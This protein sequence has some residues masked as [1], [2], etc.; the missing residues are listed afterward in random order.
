[1][2]SAIRVV[3]TERPNEMILNMGPQHPSTHGVC[4]LLL[5]VDGEKAVK[6]EP[7]IGYLHRGVEK[8]AE[9]REYFQ[10]I[11]H[12]D[13]M[14]YVAALPHNLAY[15]MAVEELMGIEVPERAEYIRVIMQE[16]QRLASHLLFVA[17]F[18]ADLGAWTVLMYGFR[19]RER[20]LDLIEMASGARLTPSYI[21][22][23][24]VRRDI[25]KAFVERCRE[26]MKILPKYFE[27]YERYFYKNE[28]FLKRC[29][30]VGILNAKDAINLGV[31]GPILRASGVPY[32]IRRI[33]PY[34]IYDRFDFE[35]ITE[36][37]GDTLARFKVRMNEMKESIKIVNQALDGLPEGEFRA[38]VPKILKPPAGEVYSR[39]ESP[40]GELGY[41][42]VSDGASKG[43]YRLKIRS[44]A[45]CNL[46]AFS[47]FGEGD[48]IPDVIA[49][50]ASIDIVMGEVD[51]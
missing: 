22:I 1:M 48:I 24:G 45:F 40:R 23:G 10:F 14:D 31:T 28:I 37:E 42:L 6:I 15:A 30:G 7:V 27:D 29:E 19:E 16:L 34:S 32:D 51:R 3:K 36:K 18:G 26:T 46:S 13:R 39:V 2:E 21:W 5:K 49:N 38:K 8:I 9:N 41:Y 12:T 25:S 33:D 11:P 44:P 43:P 20:V 35:I 47:Y 50:F 4:R 17:T